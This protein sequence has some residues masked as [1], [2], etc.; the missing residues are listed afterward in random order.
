MGE[1]K[2]PGN[3]PGSNNKTFDNPLQGYPMFIK[4]TWR[5]IL[6]FSVR[7]KDTLQKG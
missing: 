5:I 7:K 6:A 4:H 3:H 2:T 1:E